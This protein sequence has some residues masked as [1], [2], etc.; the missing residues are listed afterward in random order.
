MQDLVISGIIQGIEESL[1]KGA[2]PKKYYKIKVGHGD[3]T[4]TVNSYFKPG[5]VGESVSLHVRESEYKVGEETRKSKWTIEGESATVNPAP[6]PSQPAFVQSP[7]GTI[8]DFSNPDPLARIEAMVKILY[9]AHMEEKRARVRSVQVGATTL[10]P[11]VA[12]DTSEPRD[13]EIDM[14][15]VDRAMGIKDE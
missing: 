11:P 12:I 5:E 14:S 6:A 8:P 3:H 7:E 15:A 10:N 4:Q 1:T 13:D 2:T 9:N